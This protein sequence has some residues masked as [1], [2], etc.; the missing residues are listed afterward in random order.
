MAE[1]RVTP[2]DVDRRLLE[3]AAGEEIVFTPGHYRAPLRL[4]CKA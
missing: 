2:A 1:I 4:S 3:V